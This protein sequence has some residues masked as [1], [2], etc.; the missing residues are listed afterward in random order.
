ML[1]LVSGGTN[2]GLLH[3]VRELATTWGL[4]FRVPDAGGPRGDAV[5][6]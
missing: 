3:V 2:G 1:H 5:M 4:L 6:G